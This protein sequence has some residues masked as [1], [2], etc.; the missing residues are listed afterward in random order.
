MGGCAAEE[1]FGG[2]PLKG[3]RGG[4]GGN[5]TASW[6]GFGFRLFAQEGKITDASEK[7]CQLAGDGRFSRKLSIP[8]IFLEESFYTCFSLLISLQFSGKLF[9]QIT[10]RPRFF[11]WKRQNPS[12]GNTDL[13]WSV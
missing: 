4:N 1:N 9:S 3:R 10:L 7:R 11:S 8:L 12:G 5:V 6:F 2:W 13:R